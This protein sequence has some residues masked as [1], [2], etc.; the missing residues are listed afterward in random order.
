MKFLLEEKLDSKTRDKMKDSSF[1]LPDE[2]KFPLNDAKHVR[3][4]IA[5]FRYCPG[6][7]KKSLAKRIIAAARKFNVKISEDSH[8]W[9]LAHESTSFFD[10]NTYDDNQT[11][12]LEVRRGRQEE[13]EDNNDDLDEEINDDDVSPIDYTDMA[14]DTE[15]EEDDDTPI[16]Y[17]GNDTDDDDIDPVDYTDD[18]NTDDNPEGETE[19]EPA[20]LADDNPDEPIDYTQDA[21]AENGPDEGDDAPQ[22]YTQDLNNNE[23][24][25]NENNSNVKPEDIPLGGNTDNNTQAQQNP[26]EGNADD[27]APMDY[28]QDIDSGDGGDGMDV[29][30]DE[31]N[32]DADPNEGDLAG[33]QPSGGTELQNMQN[34]VFSNLS[35]EQMKIKIANIKQSYI[36]LYNDVVEILERLSVVNKSSDNLESINFATISLNELKTMLNDALTSTFDT[37]SLVENQITLQ[38]FLAIYTM[39]VKILEK[40]SNKKNDSDNKK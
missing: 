27:D 34:D 10:E 3:S 26:E 23:S 25:P 18:I 20:T 37:K 31:T 7:K 4:A 6:D 30:P 17:T 24:D 32:P 39:V 16:D 19:D 11:V 15:A 14:N 35:P 33:M 13:D 2:R 36:D 9:R 40:V 38:R 29:N 8:V 28:T 21:D 22:D 5:F 1:G 12:I